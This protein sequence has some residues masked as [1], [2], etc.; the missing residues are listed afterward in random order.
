MTKFEGGSQDGADVSPS[1][2]AELLKQVFEDLQYIRDNQLLDIFFPRL[3]DNDMS[4]VQNR[5]TISA[6][7]RVINGSGKNPYFRYAARTPL[8]VLQTKLAREGIDADEET[9][10]IIK[11]K[12]ALLN[13]FQKLIT[14]IEVSVLGVPEMDIWTNEIQNRSIALWV[15]EPRLPGTFHWLTGMYTVGRFSHKIDQSGY[16]LNLQLLPKLPNDATELSKYQF[17]A[18]AGGVS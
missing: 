17:L 4:L 10:V 14:D 7:Q 1:E 9:A 5:W 12:A 15:H 8:V 13:Y 6:P 3:D 2:K 11:A 18:S 16:V